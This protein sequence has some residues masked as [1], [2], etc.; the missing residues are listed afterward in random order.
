MMKHAKK[1][2]IVLIGICSLCGC[3]KAD[4]LLIVSPYCPKPDVPTLPVINGNLYFDSFENVEVFML[5][6]D[7]L[8]IYIDGLRETIRCYEKMNED[9]V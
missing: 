5:R 6:D 9:I 8:R 1:W 7:S 2:L 4:P 3:A